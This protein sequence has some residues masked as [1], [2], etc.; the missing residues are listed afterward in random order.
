M[1]SQSAPL[2]PRAYDR[3]AAERRWAEWQSANGREAQQHPATSAWLEAVFGSSPYL[4]SIALARPDI[5]QAIARDGCDKAFADVMAELS[6][7]TAADATAQ[8]TALRQAKSAAALVIAAADISKAW[9]LQRITEALTELADQTTARAVTTLLRQAHDTGDLSLPDPARPEFKCGYV[10]LALGKHGGH[11]LN[12]SSDID[13]YV[14]FDEQ[15]FPYT[16]RKSPQE[17]AVRMTRDFVRMMQE[18]T[19]DGYVFRTDLRLRPDPGSTAIA[20]SRNAAT[21]Y[22]ESYGQNW[23]RAALIKARHVAGDADLAAAFLKDLETFIWRKSLDFYAIEDIRSIK[24][25]IYAHKGGATV[26]VPGHNIK[27]GRGGIREIEFFVQTQQLIWGGRFPEM[28]SAQTFTALDALTARGIVASDVRDDLKRCYVFLRTLEHR[29]QMIDDEQTQTLPESEDGLAHVAAFMGFPDVSTFTK[30]VTDALTAVEGHYARLFEESPSLAI[31]GNLVFTGAEDDPDTL[32]TLRNLGF[33]NPSAVAASVRAWHTGKYK[34]TRTLRARQILTEMIP[35]LLKTFGATLESDAAFTRF[36]QCLNRVNT[37]VQLLSVLQVNPKL[38]ALVAEIMGDAP[39]L[40]ERITA[41]PTLLDAVLDP[42]FFGNLKTRAEL[43]EDISAA[44]RT[45]TDFESFLEAVRR[46]S[47]EQRFR[48]GLH[49][50]RGLVDT[51]GGAAA[52]SDIAETIL[53]VVTP[54]VHQEFAAQ[55]G[56]IPG[57]EIA[58]I[59]YGKLGSR[60]LTPASDLDLVLVYSGDE[61]ASAEGATRHLPASAYYIRVAQRLVTA[62]TSQS[63]QGRLYDVDLRLRPNG[64]KGPL[65]CSVT[66]FAKYMREDAWTWEHM[67]LTRA[68]VIVGSDNIRRQ[69]DDVITDAL[70]RPREDDALVCAIADMRRR[71]RTEHKAEDLWDVKRRKGGLIDIEFIAQYLRLK[72]PSDRNL[73]AEG[74]PGLLDHAVAAGQL[75]RADRDRLAGAL[76][77]MTRAQVLMRLMVAED[78]LKPPFPE[79]LR[80]RLSA[81]AGTPSFEALEKRMM[82]DAGAVGAIYDRIIDLPGEV[83]RRKFPG[84]LPH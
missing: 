3:T 19:A 75:D 39:R 36:D 10:V 22:Y 80:R 6:R 5:V 35:T 52:F 43:A 53:D 62:L 49:I 46:W 79:G 37:G 34:A 33:T 76:D 4:S 72:V 24:R 21:I 15:Q 77:V 54:R 60:E 65:A 2:T 57:S 16:G 17:F 32:A 28:R 29:L 48:T 38:L 55:H 25:Q 11:E 41:N 50:L 68:R 78:Q 81:H 18:R 59:A 70:N 73:A 56:R 7:A 84:E 74:I 63:G 20:V 69:I 40:A 83:A 9:T 1:F 31:E 14:L 30:A 47:N 12:Y 27:L 67:A 58:I 71:M 13:L 8:M 23:E 45:T 66:A 51:A 64:D 82:D 61:A 42:E 26:K 44:T